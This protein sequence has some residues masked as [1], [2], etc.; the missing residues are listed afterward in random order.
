MRAC[1]AVTGCTQTQSSHLPWWT[2]VWR[3]DRSWAPVAFL[4]L[5]CVSQS[6][7][8]GQQSAPEAFHAPWGVLMQRCVFAAS[9]V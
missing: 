2:L 4:G 7:F 5:A 9:G 8:R 6:E 1:E 3:A